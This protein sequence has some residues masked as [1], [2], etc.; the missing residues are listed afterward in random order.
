MAIHIHIFRHYF[1]TNLYRKTQSIKRVQN[2]LGH[3]NSSNTDIYTKM[4]VFR[5]EE[6]YSATARTVEEACKLVE[7]GWSYVTEIDGIKIFRKQK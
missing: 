6:Y 2:D 3:K 7:D 1:A 5:E 4:V